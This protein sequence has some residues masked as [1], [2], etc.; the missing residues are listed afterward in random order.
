[1]AVVFLF[2]QIHITQPILE[3]KFEPVA[4]FALVVAS[5]SFVVAWL[6]YIRDRPKARVIV[7]KD[8]VIPKQ[9]SDVKLASVTVTNTGRRP[10]TILAVG[11][12][13]LWNFRQTVL[14]P[15]ISQQQ[16]PKR[17]EE[18]E[19]VT[20]I[21]DKGEGLP[22]GKWKKVAYVFASDTVGKE[23][24][25]RIAS[26]FRAATHRLLEKCLWPIFRTLYK[27]EDE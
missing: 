12:R 11:Y 20:Y 13:E 15:F 2:A 26:P 4:T 6:T 1:M 3:L 17:L 14:F 8:A 23:Y 21:I 5:V 22:E 16:N 9:K 10:L 25:L 19:T 18:A 27:K 24:R 7:F